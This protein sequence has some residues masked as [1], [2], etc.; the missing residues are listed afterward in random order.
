[1]DD[2]DLFEPVAVEKVI[3]G[4]ILNPETG[5]PAREYA[6]GGKVDGLVILKKDIEGFKAGDLLLLEHRPPARSTRPISSACSWTASC[7][8][9]P[10]TCRGSW[11]PPSP[12]C[13]FNV[14]LKPNIGRRRMRARPSTASG[15]GW[16]WTGLKSTIAAT[17]VS[18]TS[19]SRRSKR[20]CGMQRISS[21]KPGRKTC[22]R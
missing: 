21:L 22:S 16:K 14:I 2:I 17:C 3:N 18:P 19:G 9:I 5:R 1:M 20:S 11:A 8:Y 7:S 10:C 6:Y 4:E 12:A 13:L 15:L